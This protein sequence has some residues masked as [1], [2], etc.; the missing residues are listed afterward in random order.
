M[1]SFS[2]VVVIEVSRPTMYNDDCVD[3]SVST[4]INALREILIIM[5]ELT[6]VEYSFSSLLLIPLSS[7]SLCVHK[8]PIFKK[9][10]LLKTELFLLI[11]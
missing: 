9:W 5:L 7:I 11:L 2:R 6:A 3:V 8:A 10:L 1:P 4:R